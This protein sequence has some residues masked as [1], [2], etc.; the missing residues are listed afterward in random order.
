MISFFFSHE[1]SNRR[2]NN[3]TDSIADTQLSIHVAYYDHYSCS[4][5]YFLNAIARVLQMPWWDS[6]HLGFTHL[7]HGEL[8]EGAGLHPRPSCIEERHERVSCEGMDSVWNRIHKPYTDQTEWPMDLDH[9]EWP[10]GVT[11]TAVWPSER[12]WSIKLTQSEPPTSRNLC[13]YSQ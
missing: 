2:P 9:P 1:N 6:N 4:K 11:R 13:F 12:L 8:P 7:P 10:L 3:K 5:F